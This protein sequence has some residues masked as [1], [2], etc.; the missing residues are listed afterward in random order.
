M[1]RASEMH[2]SSAVVVV[3]LLTAGVTAFVPSSITPCLTRFCR[4]S[5]PSHQTS[6][7]RSR[8]TDHGL[9]L[10]A[11]EGIGGGGVG[12]MLQQQITV[13]IKGG[14]KVK[15]GKKAEA[16]SVRV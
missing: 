15:D 6:K 12:G 5:R 16:L 9:L 10:A 13:E 11:A 14:I 7:T 4:S 3:L 1:K 8:G 2:C